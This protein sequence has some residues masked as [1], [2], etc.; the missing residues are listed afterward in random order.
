MDLI[1][2][3]VIIDKMAVLVWGLCH[4]LTKMSLICGFHNIRPLDNAAA[5]T[6][7]DHWIMKVRHDFVMQKNSKF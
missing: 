7:L 6:T 4:V 3:E 5:Y 1:H 2:I